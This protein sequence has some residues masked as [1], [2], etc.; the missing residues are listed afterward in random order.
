MPRGFESLEPR[1]ALD[2]AT[3]STPTSIPLPIT[4]GGTPNLAPALASGASATTNQPLPLLGTRVYAAPIGPLPA[5]AGAAPAGSTLPPLT[6]SAL[7]LATFSRLGASTTFGPARPA[8]LPAPPR[9]LYAEG[10]Q[11]PKTPVNLPTVIET[12][13]I[14]TDPPGTRTPLGSF[15]LI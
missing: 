2:G 13:P 7:S 3:I 4:L 12:M 14:V 9:A 10:H 15:T 8:N 11:L 1:H 6:L 5:P